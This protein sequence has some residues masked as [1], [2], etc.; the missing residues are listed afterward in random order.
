MKA[1][2][3]DVLYA[4]TFESEESDEPVEI[5]FAHNT[6]S[7]EFMQKVYSVNLIGNESA[8][9]DLSLSFFHSKKSSVR[10]VAV[11]NTFLLETDHP[12]AAFFGLVNNLRF[13]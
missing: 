7:I 11:I 12:N 6:A 3:D 4:L 1:F 8:E 10:P 13:N 9:T 2:N 5:S